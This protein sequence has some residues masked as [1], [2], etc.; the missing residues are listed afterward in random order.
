[1]TMKTKIDRKVAR[2]RFPF[3]F[4]RIFPG[5][6]AMLLFPVLVCA[7]EAGSY[8]AEVTGFGGIHHFPGASKAMVGG[9]IGGALGTN[10]QLFVES[11]YA[12]LGFGTKLVS[13]GGGLNIGL[14]APA[15]KLAPYVI[16]AGGLGLFSGSGESEKAASFGAGI[17]VRYFLGTNWGVRPEFRWQRFQASGG[18][19]NSYLL[20]A[21]LFYRFGS[22]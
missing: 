9:A 16:V 18:G 3:P 21:G 8:K 11:N 17:G 19:L 7:A 14:G 5:L 15:E 12:P 6:P 10:S 22:K 1:M 4:C 2:I 13:F 20:T